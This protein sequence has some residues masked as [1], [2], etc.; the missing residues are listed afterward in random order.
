MSVY[1]LL[2]DG[3][4]K[5]GYSDS[6]DARVKNLGAAHYKDFSV[7][8]VVPGSQSFERAIHVRLKKYRIKGEW[9]RDC[10]EVRATI[11]AIQQSGYSSIDFVE[12]VLRDTAD[13]TYSLALVAREI[14]PR[15]TAE[16][17][18]EYMGC[19][20][21]NACY[22]LARS[23]TRTG[24]RAEFFR[25]LFTGVHGPR[26]LAAWGIGSGDGPMLADILMAGR[27]RNPNEGRL[28][29]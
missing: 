24:M 17:L 11:S 20:E 10:P 27:S 7:I 4:I 19:S 6:P 26:F 14:W 29:Q 16:N 13:D 8:S 28:K 2:S 5:V 21:R 9:F 23:G 22:F 12:P 3:H 15:R 1:F 25:R 18:A